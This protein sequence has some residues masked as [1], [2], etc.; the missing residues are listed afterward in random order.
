MKNLVKYSIALTL[1]CASQVKAQTQPLDFLRTEVS[2]NGVA[3]KYANVNGS[4][5]VLEKWALGSVKTVD[6]ALKKDILL[7]YDEIDDIVIMN[8]DNDKMLAFTV[9]VAEFTLVDPKTNK[10]RTFRSGFTATKA[11]SEKAFFEVLQ[12][13]KVKFLKKN[14]KV[15]SESKEYSGAINK[16]VANGI[17]YYLVNMDNTPIA[18]KLDIKSIGA[19]LPDK[20]VQL[21]DYAKAEKLN[22]KQEEDVTKLIAYYNT[23]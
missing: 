9:P 2:V 3:E 4:P 19:L 1:C 22:L 8:G 20:Q 11:G 6:Q 15:I 5:Y 21:T 7:K 12:D 14:H 16:T 18:V 23:L 17:K 13:G 10:I